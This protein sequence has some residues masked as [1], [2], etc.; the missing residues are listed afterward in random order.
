MGE[1]GIFCE[2]LDIYII[3]AIVIVAQKGCANFPCVTKQGYLKQGKGNMKKR[4]ISALVI[5]VGLFAVNSFAQTKKVPPLIIKYKDSSRITINKVRAP[6]LKSDRLNGAT[7]LSRENWLQIHTAFGIKGGDRQ[8]WAD[9]LEVE[10]KVFIPGNV[11]EKQRPILLEKTVQYL[12]C[13][14]EINDIP[15]TL[16]FRPSFVE[17]YLKNIEQKDIAVSISVTANGQPVMVTKTSSIKV[18]NAGGKVPPRTYWEYP[19]DKQHKIENK[20]MAL[21]NKAETPFENI[22]ADKFLTIKEEE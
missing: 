5:G 22:E 3:F 11:R 13:P 16:Y 12:E 14:K 20:E 6:E 10:W 15:L 19:E 9:S 8:T 18:L 21:L 17:R 1:Y 4:A 2:I 7:R